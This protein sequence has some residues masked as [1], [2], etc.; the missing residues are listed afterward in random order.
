MAVMHY[1]PNILSEVFLNA[2]EMNLKQAL[3][4]YSMTVGMK[5]MAVSSAGSSSSLE[6][7][8]V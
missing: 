8:I 7:S 2:K 1:N 4:F 5:D 6:D 3:S